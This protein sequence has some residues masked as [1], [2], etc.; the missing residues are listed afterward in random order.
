MAERISNINAS[1]LALNDKLININ[2]VA[3]VMKGG[4]RLSFSALVVT[5]DGAG[6]GPEVSEETPR[7]DCVIPV[8][9]GL[10]SPLRSVPPNAITAE[11]LT[12]SHACCKAWACC[13]IMTMGEMPT[14]RPPFAPRSTES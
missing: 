8:R 3:K 9:H 13:E 7:R 12:I 2:R 11:S 1:E 14:I 6:H 5:G 10:L 4:K